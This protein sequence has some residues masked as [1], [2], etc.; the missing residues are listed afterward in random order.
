MSYKNLFS[1]DGKIAL[2][3]GV[4]GLGGEIARGL[5]EFGAEV[6]VADRDEIRAKGVARTLFSND[7]RAPESALE[8]DITSEESVTDV[9]DRVSKRFRRIDVVINTVG[10]NIFKDAFDL[11]LA[12]FERLIRIN[13]TGAWNLS[14]VAAQAMV[15]F[16][17]G[18]IVHLSSVTAYRGSPG[19][20]AYAAAKAGLINMVKTLAIEW[21]QRGVYVNAISPILTDTSINREWL[22][23]EAGRAEQFAAK[24]PLGRL[25]DPGD[26]V[27]P[28]VF[29]ASPASDFLVGQTLSVD[30]G[31]TVRHPLLG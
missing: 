20:S 21:V 23:A 12:E 27:G 17:G 11:S 31:A 18:K 19:Q 22:H 30:G 1:L 28:V 26:F 3:V 7:S 14:R 15:E 4:G 10:F 5:H 6:V 2:C 8:I 16:G 9:I 24:I 25:G 29:L 13:L